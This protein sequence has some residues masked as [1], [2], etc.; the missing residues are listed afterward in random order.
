MMRV[1]LTKGKNLPCASGQ[2]EPHGAGSVVDV[3]DSVGIRLVASGAAV[4]I[5]S[6]PVAAGTGVENA[7]AAKK[8]KINRR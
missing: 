8:G 3:P 6:D 4:V 7:D 2:V 1:R 5:A